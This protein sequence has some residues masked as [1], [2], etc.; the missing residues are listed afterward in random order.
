MKFRGWYIP[1]WLGG[2]S[3]VLYGIGGGEWFV[4]V[5]GILII[6]LPFVLWFAVKPKK[7]NIMLTDILPKEEPKQEETPKEPEIK[8]LFF[9][10]EDVGEH[11]GILKKVHKK[12]ENDDEFFDIPQLVLYTRG[13]AEEPAFA[14]YLDHDR[15]GNVTGASARQIYD[16][17]G[18]GW[19]VSGL[20]YDIDCDYDADVDD[21][22]YTCDVTM[23]LK[24]EDE[25]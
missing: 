15:I 1:I 10:V 25:N 24:K 18:E 22:V 4:S 20:Y 5:V 7:K 19:V 23:A 17:Y 9:T 16:A 11:Q 12:Q 21:M 3:C 6:A 14:I 2:L 13:T 8:K